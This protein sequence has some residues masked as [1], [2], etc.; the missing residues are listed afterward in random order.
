[1]AQSLVTTMVDTGHKIYLE[2]NNRWGRRTEVEQD[3]FKQA[4]DSFKHEHK[5]MLGKTSTECVVQSV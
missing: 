5:L 4:Q 2:Y 3:S 1:M